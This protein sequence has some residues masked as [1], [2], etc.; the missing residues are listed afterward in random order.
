MVAMSWSSINVSC[1]VSHP[2]AIHCSIAA[3]CCVS[4]LRDCDIRVLLIVPMKDSG[5]MCVTSFYHTRPGRCSTSAKG[6]DHDPLSERLRHVALQQ[7]GANKTPT[8]AH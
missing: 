2:C 7:T 6:V 5:H 8:S 4:V 3:A 1:P